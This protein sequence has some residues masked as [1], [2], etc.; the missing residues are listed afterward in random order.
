MRLLLITATISLVLAFDANAQRPAGGPARYDSPEPPP[1]IEPLPVDLFT[2][3]NFYFDTQYWSD[4]RY[5]RCNTPAQLTNMWVAGRVGNW[6]DCNY[7]ISAEEIFSP[8]PYET[9]Q[10]HF[11]ALRVQAE[12]NDTLVHHSRETLPEW[13]GWYFRGSFAQPPAGQWTNGNILQTSTMISLLTPE[14]QQRMTQM[15][16]HEAVNNAPQWMASFC[17]PEGLMRWWYV[18]GIRDMEVLVTPRQVQF[19]A[20]VADNFIRKVL[21]DQEHS[22]LIPQWYGESVGFWDD[23][24][25]VSWTANVQGWTTSHSMF[26]FSNS[27]EVIEIIRQDED[28]GDLVVEAIFYDQE[29]FVRPLR[30]V[31]PWNRTGSI[32]DSDQ[33]YLFVECR[34][35]NGIVLGADGRPSQLTPFDEGY[36]DFLGRPWALN[37]EKFF[38]QGWERPSPDTSN[39]P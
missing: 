36:I 39:Q 2:T 23:Q 17:Y 16:Y 24:T 22:T 26:E 14:Y 30:I 29:A 18:W 37:W 19:L 25:L 5:A 32:E 31:T 11:A 13:D 7:G 33:R 3:E 6:G 27:L 10:E 4:P 12:E 35:E 1:G 28:S 20:G 34:V 21:I 8:Y 38:E 15:N 9:A